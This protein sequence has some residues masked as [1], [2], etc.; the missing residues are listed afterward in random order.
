M[1][2]VKAFLKPKQKTTC[3]VSEYSERYYK[4]IETEP[5]VFKELP[6]DVEPAA[7]QYQCVSITGYRNT[8]DGSEMSNFM[9]CPGEHFYKMVVFENIAGKTI[10]NYRLRKLSVHSDFPRQLQSE[11]V[12][13]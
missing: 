2:T 4:V 8:P 1:F 6:E 12:E 3:A 7:G 11:I 5:G 9:V 10:D 13:F